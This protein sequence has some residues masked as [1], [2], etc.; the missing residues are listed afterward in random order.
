[1]YS[2]ALFYERDGR[3]TH[4]VRRRGTVNVIETWSNIVGNLYLFIIPGRNF[5]CRIK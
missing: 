5:S 1:M 2:P 3:G 4:A